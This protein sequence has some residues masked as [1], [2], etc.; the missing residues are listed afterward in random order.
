MHPSK[1]PKM[2]KERST[3]SSRHNYG[4][5]KVLDTAQAEIS[6]REEHDRDAVKSYLELQAAHKVGQRTQVCL[7]WM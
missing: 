7:V 4:L 6:V 2:H 5:Q 3:G 1:K